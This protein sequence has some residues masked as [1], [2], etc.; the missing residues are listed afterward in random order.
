MRIN[1]NIP[2]LRSLTSLNSTNSRMATTSRR[3]SSGVKLESAADDPAGRAISNKIR[4][5]AL[6]LSKASQNASAAISLVQTA[7]GAMNEIHSMLQRMNELAVK[8]A[9]G[10]NEP[11]DAQK[12]Q[13][14]ITSLTAE[15]D[16]MSHKIEYNKIKVLSSEADR[17]VDLNVTKKNV[18][19]LRMSDSL[20]DGEYQFVI[21]KTLKEPIAPATV[22]DPT[23][24]ANYIPDPK[25]LATN[26]VFLPVTMAIPT[27]NNKW[28]FAA[29]KM[30][31]NDIQ[32]EFDGTETPDQAF[33][34]LRDAAAFCDITVSKGDPTTN[35]P[36]F[37]QMT[38]DNPGSRHDIIVTGDN[39]LLR[40]LGIVSPQ[41]QQY[42]GKDA[43]I[44]LIIPGTT[45]TYSTAAGAA[46]VDLDTPLTQN[47]TYK[48]DGN[49]ITITD[50]NGRE[51]CFDL[52]VDTSNP[53]MALPVN[54]EYWDP[55]K[56]A[57]KPI[58]PTDPNYATDLAKYADFLATGGYVFHLAKIEQGPMKVQIGA[59]KNMEMELHIPKINAKTLE[60]DGINTQYSAG[61]QHAIGATSKAIDIISK[62]RSKM[63]AYQNR[64]E[65]SITNL[66]NA[67]FNMNQALS[68]IVDADMAEEMAN[69]AKDNVL[70]QAGISVIAQANQ[71]PQQILQL[72]S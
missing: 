41:V 26:T 38:C 49:R 68:R 3:L 2:A 1:T 25:F 33:I 22:T 34:K 16:S 52:Q 48:A 65:H 11:L 5:Q 62:I 43:D 18:D 53:A 35:Y 59:G 8:A 24:P 42:K 45:V 29:G 72:L 12:I 60:L 6:G 7:E 51:L 61:A 69:Y 13:E 55:A 56:Y 23:N 9:N 36:V 19:V 54:G 46:T 27:G 37:T 32:I 57:A 66:D 70:Y 71:R 31:I 14:E 21:P 20:L 58:D 44:S 40:S 30:Q 28:E 64:L 10:T 47:A 63:G 67:E 50:I 17:I 39:A 4:M 15:I